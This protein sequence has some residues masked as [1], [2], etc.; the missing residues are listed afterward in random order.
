MKFH[1]DNQNNTQYEIILNKDH[2]SQQSGMVIVLKAPGYIFLKISCFEG[3][4][5]LAIYENGEKLNS[6]L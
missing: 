1:D 2:L 5:H 6:K 3:R 4:K